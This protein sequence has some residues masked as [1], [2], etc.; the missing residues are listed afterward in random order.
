[1]ASE[2]YGIKANLDVC[3]RPTDKIDDRWLPSSEAGLTVNS[4]LVDFAIFLGNS[5]ESDPSLYDKIV[6]HTPTTEYSINHLVASVDSLRRQPTAISIETKA[7]HSTEDEA[8][9]QLGIC[10]C[11]QIRRMQSLVL[12]N[13]PAEVFSRKMVPT[14]H[15]ADLFSRLVLPLIFVQSSRWEVMF[16][17]LDMGSTSRPD[18]PNPI[19]RIGG[20]L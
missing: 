20:V 5:R 7:L 6:L 2:G 19:V 17:R 10:V 9:V 4:G 14:D 12:A 8:R 18:R 3:D 16:A 1:M 11:S 13:D 15:K